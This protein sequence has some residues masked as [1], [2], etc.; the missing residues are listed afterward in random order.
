LRCVRD[1]LVIEK[2]PERHLPHVLV[3]SHDRQRELLTLA[4]GVCT[5]DIGIGDSDPVKQPA[6]PLF[7][8]KLGKIDV[9]QAVQSSSSTH[10]NIR[11]LATIEL[12]RDEPRLGIRAQAQLFDCD[13]QFLIRDGA[14]PLIPLVGKKR[15][16]I[17]PAGNRLPDFI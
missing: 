10:G 6:E 11:D 15:D 1:L 12:Y 7:G 17:R 16:E 5:G 4:N 13:Q 3:R 14:L 8:I 2:I 9:M